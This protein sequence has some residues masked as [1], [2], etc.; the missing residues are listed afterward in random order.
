MSLCNNLNSLVSQTY[1]TAAKDITNCSNQVARSHTLVQVGV[2]KFYLLG[3]FTLFFFFPSMRLL[4]IWAVLANLML[5]T[6]PDVGGTQILVLQCSTILNVTVTI[7]Y[8][9]LETSES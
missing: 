6:F 9:W 2:N 1:L 7:E 4:L 5:N 8:R 3:Y